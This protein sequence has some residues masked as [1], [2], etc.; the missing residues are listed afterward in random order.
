MLPADAQRLIRRAARGFVVIEIACPISLASSPR[1][2]MGC[3]REVDDAV[4]WCGDEI[5]GE[6]IGHSDDHQFVPVGCNCLRH[7]HITIW[8][9]HH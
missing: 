5:G 4:C 2:C 8:P 7:N 1:V 9:G 6:Y 3:H